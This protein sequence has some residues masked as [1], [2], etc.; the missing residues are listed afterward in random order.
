MPY[1]SRIP[2]KLSGLAARVAAANRQTADRVADR[3]K[4]NVP[5]ATGALHDSIRVI[6]SSRSTN[7]RV[8][9]GNRNVF[10]AHMVEFGTVKMPA[11]PFLVPAAEA[12]RDGHQL[13]VKRALDG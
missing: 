9:V 5:R 7:G 6:K 13:T 10:Y 8:R 4:Q 12:E 11:Q 1:T 3:A 2:R